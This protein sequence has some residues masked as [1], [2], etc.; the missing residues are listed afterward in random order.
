MSLGL[1]NRA[2]CVSW[3][4]DILLHML[5]V[6]KCLDHVFVI[7]YRLVLVVKL[8]H[9][10]PSI[11]EMDVQ[12]VS[13]RRNLYICIRSIDNKAI[14]PLALRCLVLLHVNRRHLAVM[15]L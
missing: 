4:P 3:F 8:G 9:K 10:N 6:F 15:R 5:L 13:D 1:H 11:L 2:S 14:F 12:V 7:D